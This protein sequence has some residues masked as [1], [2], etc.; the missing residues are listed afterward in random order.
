VSSSEAAAAV[1]VCSIQSIFVVGVAIAFVVSS[2]FASLLFAV[3]FCS[4]RGGDATAGRQDDEKVMTPK[5][6]A[7]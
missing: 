5:L 3:A 4:A 1:V 7:V 6:L 2:P